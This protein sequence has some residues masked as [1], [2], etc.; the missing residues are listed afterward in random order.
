MLNL[1]MVK[2]RVIYTIAIVGTTQQL[3]GVT[4]LHKNNG[5]K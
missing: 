1:Y 5:R 4:L 2:L 3:K